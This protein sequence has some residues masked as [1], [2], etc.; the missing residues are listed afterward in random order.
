VLLFKIIS[1]FIG[2]KSQI[3]DIIREVF[4]EPECPIK[5]TNS[6]DFISKSIF[7][8]TILFE[9]ANVILSI[10]IFFIFY[11]NKQEFL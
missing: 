10:F 3:I 6:Q 7:L 4:Q 2:L 5:K 11:Q 1:H 9:K 8:K